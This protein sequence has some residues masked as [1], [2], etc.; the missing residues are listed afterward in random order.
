MQ[1][2]F[3]SIT[4]SKFKGLLLAALLLIFFL[5]SRSIAGLFLDYKWWTEMGQTNTWTRMW[6]YRWV[7]IVVQW[8]GSVCRFVC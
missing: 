2:S 6:L 5:F 1:P 7:P 3:P 4:P 8:F